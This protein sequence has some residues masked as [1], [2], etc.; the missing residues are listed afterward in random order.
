MPLGE[1]VDWLLGGFYSD[2]DA[3]YEQTISALNASTGAHVGIIRS[4][5]FPTTYREHAAFTDLTFHFTDRFD[6]QV[7]GRES[8]IDQ[9]YI[10]TQTGPAAITPGT[11]ALAKSDATA[12]TYLVTP[13]LRISPDLMVYAR[14]ASGYRP[15]GPNADAG[16]GTPPE[17]NPDKTQ[18]YEVGVKGEM[19]GGVMSF[20]ASLFYI[21]WKDIQLLVTNPTTL[22]AY[23]SNGG[24]AKS[25]GVELSVGA[26]PMTGLNLNAWVTW[27]DAT[28]T[29]NLPPGSTVVG[30]DGDR[31]PNTAK[32]S[33]NVSVDQQFP[34]SAKL[35]GVVGGSWSYVGERLSVLTGGTGVRQSF[36]S[37]SKVDLRGGV[38]NGSWDANL[39]V[40]NLT[41]K[42]GVL[43]GG[44][45]AFP[46]TAFL[47]IQPRTYG[48]SVAKAF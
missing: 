39:F 15:G 17:F 1:H 3:D 32:F 24:R 10:Q 35:T 18:N 28:L 22:R 37:Y 29:E 16:P 2:E 8:W 27:N 5:V 23:N 48:V 38:R 12:F 41:D 44:L 25:Q 45:G 21:D 36:P 7:G 34:L 19:A 33:G 4:T 43:Y 13:R 42:R 14:L 9:S 30:H 46:P 26:A 40:T 20:D 6:V 31:L 11:S 47:Y